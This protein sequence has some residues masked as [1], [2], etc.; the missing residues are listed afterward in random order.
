MVGAGYVGLVAGACLAEI[1]HEVICV[2]NDARKIAALQAGETVIHEEFLPEL[3]TRNHGRAESRLAFTT[4]LAAAVRASRVVFIAVGTP[5]SE[6][7]EHDLSWLEAVCR[8]VAR[9][10]DS[11]KLIVVKSTVPVGTSQWIRRIL[12]RYGAPLGS[13]AVAS[14]PEFLREGRGVTDFLYPDRII[15]GSDDDR[16]TS[17]LRQV[18]KPLTDGSYARGQDAVPVPDEAIVPA[19]LIVTGANSAELIKHAANAFL[20]MKISFINAIS[21]ICEPAGADIQEVCEGMGAD[22]R[23]GTRFM[24]PGIGYGG[25]CFPKDLAAFRAVA[26]EFGYDFR[27]LEEV[28]RINEEQRHVFLRKVRSALWTLKGKR[29]AVLGLAFKGG[30]DDIRESPAIA[31]IRMLLKERCEIV[32]YDPAATERARRE[33]AQPRQAKDGRAGDPAD[34]AITFAES[35]YQAAEKSDALLILT[36]WEEFAALDFKRLRQVM[37]HPILIDGRNLYSRAEMERAGFSYF[38]VGRQEALPAPANGKE[39]ISSNGNPRPKVREFKRREV[40]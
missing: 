22:Q 31:V 12:V 18:Y 15:V 35:A 40:A 33:F 5:P 9:Q 34:A 21:N 8:D 36:D 4:N 32:A 20:A 26:H 6:N 30:T 19:R 29:L 28:M 24:R 37:N 3:L 23:I 27:L 16:C 13:F 39:T 17:I 2:D 38:S 10:I 14:N 7:G 25:S 11:F 1:G